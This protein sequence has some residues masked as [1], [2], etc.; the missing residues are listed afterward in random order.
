MTA[1]G[2]KLSLFDLLCLGVNAIVG[3]GIYL[4]PGKLAALLGPASI[5]AFLVTGLL[6]TLI[7]LSFAEVSGRFDRSGGPYVYAREAFGAPVGY[8]VGWTCWAAAVMSWAAVT[9]GLLFQLASIHPFFTSPGVPPTLAATS[10][11]LLTTI[12]ILGVKPGAI[13]TDILTVAKLLPL[14]L[15]LVIGLAS[16]SSTRLI[17]FA[18]QGYQGL[19]QASF[20][21]FFAFQGFEVVP[22]PAGDSTNPTRDAPLAVLISVGVAT[23]LYMAIQLTAVATTPHLAGHGEPLTAMARQLLGPAGALLIAIAAVVSMFGFNAGVALAAPRYLEA[24]ATDKLLP[25]PLAQRHPQRH[26]PQA[27]ILLTSFATL[28]LTLGLDFTRL[29]DLSVIF[30]AVQYLSTTASVPVLRR[31]LARKSS[32]FALPAGPLIPLA[33]FLA[34]TALIGSR[35]MAQ[36]DGRKLILQFAALSALGLVAALPTWIARHL[37]SPKG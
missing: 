23:L 35:L 37:S 10:I 5:L 27:A 3:S 18:P 4:L 22:V 9:R 15:L 36:D 7:A 29:V 11:I 24:L 6:S 19:S 2:R 12:N 13:T 33:G 25:A 32:T 1:G 20:I 21:A 26:T 17:P 31:R 30:V 16:L 8:L 14:G 34:V 28:L